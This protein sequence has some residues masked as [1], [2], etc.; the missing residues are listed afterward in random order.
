M[1]P[2]RNR[3]APLID[4][5]AGGNGEHQQNGGELLHEGGSA[6][7]NRPARSPPELTETVAGLLLESN[8]LRG[9]KLPKE[10]NPARVLL[11]DAEYEALLNVAGDIDWRYRGAVPLPIGIHK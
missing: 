4:K 9:L 5:T 11:A 2:A 7:G 1:I 10:K 8:P 3:V 6:P